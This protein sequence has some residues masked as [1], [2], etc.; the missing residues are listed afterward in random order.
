LL[1]D[2]M[3]RTLRIQNYALIDDLTIEWSAGL[4]V[5][6]GE[7]GA[8]KSIILGALSLVLGEK[9]DPDAIRTGKDSASVEAVFDPTRQTWEAV[10]ELALEGDDD[11]QLAI[12]RK[13][14]REGKGGI[15]VNDHSATNATLK[16]LGDS[17][18]DLH[19][20]HEHQSL[21]RRELHLLVLDDFAGLT[22][23]AQKLAD[24]Y[25]EYR[26]TE[27][28]LNDALTELAAKRSRRDLTLAQQQELQQAN[29]ATDEIDALNR[30]QQLLGSS[31]QRHT[32]AHEI[33]DVLS[34]SEGSVL[35]VLAA[36]ARRLDSLAE[37]D[38]KLAAR[39]AELNQAV[40]AL[41]ELWRALASY[42]ESTEFSPGRLEEVNERLF[43]LQKLIRKHCSPAAGIDSAAIQELIALREQLTRELDSLELNETRTQE[44]QKRLN[45][46]HKS[47]AKE[48][49]KLSQARLKAKE[50][51]EQ[52]LNKEF[53]ELGMPKARIEAQIA[54]VEQ[55]DGLYEDN[56]TRF[57]LDARGIDDVEFLFSAN[58]GEEMKPLRKIASG[59]ELSRIMLALKSVLTDSDPVPVLV[60]DEIDTGISGRIAEAV[61]GKL[62]RL[63]KDKQVIC[64][65]H[66]PQIARFASA[67]FRVSK[68]T[69]AGRTQTRIARLGE[70]ERIEELASLLAGKEVTATARAHARELLA[71][72]KRD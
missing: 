34:E 38:P 39:K 17:L 48:A 63:A 7:T 11:K 69:K 32:L 41:D 62:S 23:S 56:G 57:R 18:V 36:C 37:L 45:T 10:T 70:P 26:R 9:A 46:L 22:A 60:F 2:F 19:G 6:T 59:G 20:Q 53:L 42:Q 58:P 68:E 21:L 8:G 47:L 65:T 52:K 35:E 30:E 66:L 13:V 64:I 29:L 55:P 16:H 40:S 71:K 49:E 15:F 27:A 25:E 24:S 43:S 3:L 28:E 33:S 12:R 61:G 31:E 51:F 54:R 72:G 14:A 1:F 5:L 67:H 50:R 4:N 44:L